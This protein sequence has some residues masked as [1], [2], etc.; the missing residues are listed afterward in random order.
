LRN[1]RRQRP[2]FP[3]YRPF[4]QIHTQVRLVQ[5]KDRVV[6]IVNPGTNKHEDVSLST[7]TGVTSKV[8]RNQTFELLDGDILSIN[9]AAITF[10]LQPPSRR[11]DE[12]PNKKH[13]VEA[14]KTSLNSNSTGPQI[15]EPE[16]MK[17]NETVASKKINAPQETKDTYSV[18]AEQKKANE[19]IQTPK[20]SNNV[21][22][23]C[24]GTTKSGK[25]CDIV[26]RLDEKGYCPFHSN[27]FKPTPVTRVTEV[28]DEEIASDVETEENESD[29]QEET[30]ELEPTETV[31]L[32][33][34]DE[35]HFPETIHKAL[36]YKSPRNVPQFLFSIPPQY[37]PKPQPYRYYSR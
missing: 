11:I 35:I 12:D 13:Q 33:T 34:N 26:L 27:Q 14:E 7:S 19:S 17:V 2:T 28:V 18:T 20:F 6:L 3:L 16:A 5:Q 15:P 31:P 8:V 25:P 36:K 30:A 32:T 23:K 24:R 21:M 1:T 9:G 29:G 10:E 4:T 22:P 37:Q